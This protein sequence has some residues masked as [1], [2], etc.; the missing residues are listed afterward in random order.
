MS[1]DT[2]KIEFELPQELFLKGKNITQTLIR[3]E[4]MK[5]LA[6]TFY[7]DGSLSL[8]KAAQIA[9]VSKQDFLDFLSS[10]NIPLNYDVHELE[11]DLSI[12]KEFLQDENSL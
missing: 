2:I 10:H 3:A 12:V 11:K 8:G 1:S 4:T 7:A 5:R 6:A 9:N